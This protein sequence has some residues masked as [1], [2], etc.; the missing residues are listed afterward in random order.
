[1]GAE[2]EEAEANAMDIDAIE[3]VEAYKPKK[4]KKKSMQKAQQEQDDE[5]KEWLGDYE[6]PKFDADYVYLGLDGDGR[7]R[8]MHIFFYFGK[9]WQSLIVSL[10]FLSPYANTNLESGYHI[11]PDCYGEAASHA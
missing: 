1:M 11:W 2:K 5:E 4:K 9:Q 6:K 10:L 3:T 7:P 8:Y